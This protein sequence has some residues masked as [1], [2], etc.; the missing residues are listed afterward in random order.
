MK[1]NDKSVTLYNMI[2]PLW[3]LW[4]FPLTWLVVL[5]ANY[6]I[7]RL[8]VK[9]TQKRCAMPDVCKND[10]YVLLKVWGFGFLSDIIGTAGMFLANAIEFSSPATDKWWYDHI[11]HPTSYNPFASVYGFLWTAACA[12]IAGV[13]IYLFNYHISFKKAGLDD[14]Q[15]KRM[16][17]NLALIT[18][19]YLLFLPT[20]WI[21]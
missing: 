11:A 16:S 2:F 14:E 18:A 12:A 1:S 8:V 6:V 3:M 21:Y 19:P 9:L 5:P 10:R 17:L 20:M 15:R 4:L 7:D 13:C